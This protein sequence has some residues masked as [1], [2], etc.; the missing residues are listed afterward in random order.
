M[1]NKFPVNVFSC[2]LMS[3]S[4]FRVSL[5]DEDANSMEGTDEV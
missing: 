5:D 3:T 2:E 1:R 4:Y